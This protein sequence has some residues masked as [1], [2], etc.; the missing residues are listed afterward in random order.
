MPAPSALHHGQPAARFALLDGLRALAALAVASLHIRDYGPLCPAAWTVLPEVV[1]DAFEYCWMG[2]PVFLVISGFVI[3]HSLRNVRMTPAA[4][5]LFLARRFVR[6]SVPCWVTVAIVSL[7]TLVPFEL[8]HDNSM[9]VRPS[10]FQIALHVF[11]LQNIFGYENIS[12]GLWTICIEMQFYV[13]YALLLG[14]AQSCS[15]SA[16]GSGGVR[17]A[18]WWLC[19]F[20]PGVALLFCYQPHADSP[21][22]AWLEG[23]AFEPDCFLPYFFGLFACGIVVYATLNGWLPAWAF[24]LY[25]AVML[26][27]AGFEGYLF[28]DGYVPRGAKGTAMGLAAG[29]LIYFA[30]RWQKLDAWLNFQPLQYLG[31]ISYSLFLIHFAVAF[32]VKTVVYRLLLLTGAEVGLE[33]PF[34]VGCCAVGGMLLSLALSI[35]AAH[36]LYVYVEEPAAQWS[37]RLG[38]SKAAAVPD[39]ASVGG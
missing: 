28:F 30:G 13:A 25:A 36:L 19:F 31:R 22:G 21:I 16:N 20:L 2:V 9:S 6:L 27:R 7:L 34:W 8:H 12:T 33:S 15:A 11:Y 29:L 24:W 26:Y 39:A 10:G 32:V 5:G 1:W 18:L 35:P 38:A 4:A 17:P 23:F 37:R 14:L 3:A